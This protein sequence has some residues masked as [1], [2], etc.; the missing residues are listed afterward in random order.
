M[1]GDGFSLLLNYFLG[2]PVVGSAQM[3]KTHVAMASTEIDRTKA[4][5][6]CSLA[7]GVGLMAGPLI[8]LCFSRMSYPGVPLLFGAHINIFTAPSYLIIT[9]C[10]I[11][12]ILLLNC[13]DGRMRIAEKSLQDQKNTM[14][15]P[16]N[17]SPLDSVSYI[18][19][20]SD[21]V[22]ILNCF[23]KLK[24]YDLDSV[25]IGVCMYTKA[26]VTLC[27]Q[28]FFAI[29]G[30][31]T[32]I[33][34]QWSSEEAVIYLSIIIASLGFSMIVWNSLYVFFNFGNKFSE[35]RAIVFSLLLLLTVYL[36]TY[37]WPFL[38]DTIPYQ[39]VDTESI[40]FKNMSMS[41]NAI[42]DLLR[43]CPRR[44]E[45]CATTKRIYMPVFSISYILAF[46]AAYPISLLNLDTLY[47]KILGPIKQG[48][49]QGIFIA[50]GDGLNIALPV[51]LSTLSTPNMVKRE[52]AR[53]KIAPPPM[54]SSASGPIVKKIVYGNRAEK[55]SE[56]NAA[57]HTHSWTL[58]VK[59]L[60]EDQ[61]ISNYV[62]KV[63][64]VL[65][66][67][68]QN[69]LRVID[70]A[71]FELSETGYGGF[72]VQMKLFF[73]DVNTKFVKTIFPLAIIDPKNPDGILVNEFY[74]EIVFDEMTEAMHTAL[75]SS[76]QKEK[77][78]EE[79][80]REM[81]PVQRNLAYY[82]QIRQ[83]L[84]NSLEAANTEI[85]AEI[86]D[87]ED[88]LSASRDLLKRA[89]K[90]LGLVLVESE[91]VPEDA[92]DKMEAVDPETGG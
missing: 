2:Y 82:E 86:K 28:G 60:D 64:F 7:P 44:F 52:N 89:G 45:W 5:G 81:E 39:S 33:A 47:S 11:G 83:K 25:A 43:G 77:D 10:I 26:V 4:V 68:Y 48:T 31:Y 75:T 67:S 14:T 91:P 72:D 71:P 20:T 87:L 24:E 57:G 18:S 9:I 78:P 55:L 66:N 90:E 61:C 56:K 85:L 51:I 59:A 21:K 15:H 50:C 30:S 34:F 69:P 41:V 92:E 74:D 58:Y 73:V 37:P 19:G 79:K 62:R 63:E 12:A 32:M 53:K 40:D 38:S 13:F 6:L 88:S 3:Y 54:M 22:H 65:H 36:C 27:T 76:V 8:Q 70:K 17:V 80:I 35:R 1:E 42:Q 23:T 46:G 84:K 29:G 49:M 16:Q